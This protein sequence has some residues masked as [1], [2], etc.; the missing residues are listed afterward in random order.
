MVKHGLTKRA[1]DSGDSAAFSSGFLASG[2]FCSQAKS[3]PAPPTLTQTVEPYIP[4]S[5][6]E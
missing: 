6:E 3:T 1:M 4:E 2:F 5:E